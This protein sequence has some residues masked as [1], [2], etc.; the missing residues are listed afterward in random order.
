MDICSYLGV[1]NEMF[2]I[3]R[4]PST[5]YGTVFLNKCTA[6]HGAFVSTKVPRDLMRTRRS[7]RR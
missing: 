4:H 7:L 3:V 6:A 5:G 2:D 1:E